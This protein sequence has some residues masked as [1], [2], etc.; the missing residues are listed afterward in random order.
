MRKPLVYFLQMQFLLLLFIALLPNAVFADDPSQTVTVNTSS[1]DPTDAFPGDTITSDASASDSNAP[2]PEKEHTITAHWTWTTA[3]VYASSTGDAGTFAP[4][5]GDYGI[6]WNNDGDDT[7]SSIKFKGIFNDPGYYIVKINVS[8]RYHDETSNT[9]VQ[10]STG[11]GYLG[12]GESDLANGGANSLSQSPNSTNIHANTSQNYH[13]IRISFFSIDDPGKYILDHWFMGKGSP[14][15]PAFGDYLMANGGLR[16]DMAIYLRDKAH[17]IPLGK[18]LNLNAQMHGELSAG[19]DGS[20]FDLTGYTL[21]HGSKSSVGDV[22]VQGLIVHQTD[23]SFAADIN[24]RWNDIIDPNQHNASDKTISHFLTKVAPYLDGHTPTDYP[25]TISWHAKCI[26][27]EP[28]GSH[29]G[30]KNSGWP[31]TSP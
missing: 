20:A 29:P 11:T 12:G 21:L 6:G 10:T 23:D 8:V 13:G 22:T 25:I 2:Q 26:F 28:G 30:I 9:D 15:A 5:T 17:G 24:Y 19:G 31:F 14:A 3:G 18:S 4:Y 7:S 16:A 27:L 1:W